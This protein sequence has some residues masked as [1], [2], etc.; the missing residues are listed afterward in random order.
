LWGNVIIEAFGT[1]VP[2]HWKMRLANREQRPV[3]INLEYLSAEPWV[4]ECHG[5]CSTDPQTGW[6]QYFF[7]PGFTEKTGGLL[8]PEKPASQTQ[9][10]VPV[11]RPSCQ[12]KPEGLSVFVFAY[13]LDA[14]SC[15][16]KEADLK[17]D[18]VFHLSIGNAGVCPP[19]ILA[20]PRTVTA[21][22]VA[23]SEF[24]EHLAQHDWLFVRGEDSFVRAQWLGKP[25][26]WQIYP[27]DDGA[28]WSKLQSFFERY[29]AG[30]ADEPRN[31]W[32]DLWLLWNG[33]HTR[34]SRAAEI[35]GN[36]VRH[37]QVIEGHARRWSEVLQ[38]QTGLIERLETLISSVEGANP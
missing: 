29:S 37:R 23:Q 31:A 16:L 6:Q 14:L 28:H 7:F 25:L 26:V 10:G 36:A 12:A 13:H 24:D 15:L 33:E 38:A 8:G 2:D 22:F 18:A 32:W 19:D 21:D 5:M 4:E 17:G 1:P 11:K 30:L 20:N 35:W 27:T 3:W 9:G 34:R